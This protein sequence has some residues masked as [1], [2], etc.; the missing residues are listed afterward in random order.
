MNSLRHGLRARSVVLPGE[1]REE[2]NQLCD[3][4]E[5]EWQPESRTAQFYLEQMAISQ[6]KLMRMEV[7]EANI[8]SETVSGKTQIPILD[9]LWQAQG[10]LERAYSRAQRELERLQYRRPHWVHRS[11]EDAEE[12]PAPQSAASPARK[13]PQ[14]PI[15]SD[16]IPAASPAT[17]VRSAAPF[18]AMEPDRRAPS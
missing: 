16:F 11:D 6:W 17:A 1:S 13:P 7:G 9:R 8:F 15:V 18:V 10:R 14:D 2:F 12:T 5:A 3:D 4:L